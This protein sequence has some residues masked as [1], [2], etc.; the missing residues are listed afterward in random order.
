MASL[1]T[2]LLTETAPKMTKTTK[3]TSGK[4]V[5]SAATSQRPLSSAQ[6]STG[7]QAETGTQSTFGDHMARQTASLPH[8]SQSRNRPA[9]SAQLQTSSASSQS[10]E[11]NE[12]AQVSSDN[13]TS[14]DNTSLSLSAIN[15]AQEDAAEKAKALTADATATIAASQSSLSSATE[16]SSSASTVSSAVTD[17]SHKP[18]DSRSTKN[19]HPEK[20]TSS[21]NTTNDSSSQTL[22][23][24]DTTLELAALSVY[25]PSFSPSETPATLSG[26]EDQTTLS[27]LSAQEI[28]VPS[29]FASSSVSE[30]TSMTAKAVR[31]ILS[32]TD[33][34]LS[35]EASS[36]NAKAEAPGQP[37]SVVDSKNSD[38]ASYLR[39]VSVS[40]VLAQT[41]QNEMTG[42]Q[43]ASSKSTD[44]QPAR[45]TNS[46]T[47]DTQTRDYKTVLTMPADI[48][49]SSI[50]DTSGAS[51]F[52]DDVRPTSVTSFSQIQ[53]LQDIATTS[54]NTETNRQSLSNNTQSLPQTKTEATP[55]PVA[56][57][58]QNVP[59]Q[60]TV[61]STNTLTSQPETASAIQNSKTA[62]TDAGQSTDTSAQV[63]MAWNP[64]PVTSTPSAGKVTASRTSPLDD[65][66]SGRTDISNAAQA[67]TA[68]V[69]PQTDDV[70]SS[71]TSEKTSADQQGNKDDNRNSDQH[72]SSD[73][74]LTA[75]M[76]LP[77]TYNEAAPFSEQLVASTASDASSPASTTTQA[78][79]TTS[80]SS[81]DTAAASD[82]SSTALNLTVALQNDDQTPLHVT[83]DKSDKS[84]GL[85]IHIG[86]DGL[87]TLNELQNH[88]HEL[89]HALENAGI[90]TAG[91]QISFGL[92]DNNADSSFSQ[93]HQSQQSP[94][95]NSTNTT[96]GSSDF[97]NAF[98]GTLSGN[99]NGD[100]SRNSWSAAAT[101][102]TSTTASDADDTSDQT[103]ALTALRTGSVNITA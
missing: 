95:D 2:S 43:T 53:S 48:K 20:L 61:V 76:T 63:Q 35:G 82:A 99:S 98:G 51:F 91:S 5:S 72:T 92:A 3:V 69:E 89:V 42:N 52:H 93:N 103:Y 8:N 54:V 27:P 30:N 39:N 23:P 59:V 41:V 31:N 46:A 34:S 58:A 101:P 25:Q 44:T 68:P 94:Q 86:A 73:R 60:P 47:T 22:P 70:A 67:Q 14:A 19:Q 28:A 24:S 37:N 64:A 7:D 78:S 10:L 62:S 81:I 55:A 75:N 97:A 16:N 17:G 21:E 65:R 40:D 13:T 100:G 12:D 50:S 80:S 18:T 33:A 74:S 88:K 79:A 9:N 26:N 49:V 71:T 66:T 38:T 84:D 90:S 87:T 56:D 36:S 4:S 11:Q 57:P 77:Q 96:A 102:M 6:S 15:M 85:N 1:V 29:S 83:I 45:P 32:G